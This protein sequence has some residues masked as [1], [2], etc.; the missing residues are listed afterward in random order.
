M[1]DLLSLLWK[2]EMGDLRSTFDVKR[3]ILEVL[4][5]SRRVAMDYMDN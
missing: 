2:I 3:V 5:L 4:V 1:C